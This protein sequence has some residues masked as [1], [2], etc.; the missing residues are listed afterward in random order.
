MPVSPFRRAVEEGLTEPTGEPTG[1]TYGKNKRKDR[2]HKRRLYQQ[3]REDLQV[4]G[5]I[6]TTTEGALRS[7]VVD[8]AD[9]A[10]PELI[11]QAI[12]NGWEVPRE[13]RPR[14]VDEL[15]SILE[16]PDEPSKMKIAAFN[17]LRMADKDQ[18]ERDHPKEEDSNRGAAVVNINVVTVDERPQGIEGLQLIEVPALGDSNSRDEN[19]LRLPEAAAVPTE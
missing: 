17:A 16:N 19:G 3:I 15:A 11:A 2:Q 7:E 5:E 13:K 1:P 9:Q 8:T 10:M 14:F 4:A 12:R 6:P 18:Y